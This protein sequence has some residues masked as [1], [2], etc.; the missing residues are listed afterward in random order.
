MTA[1]PPV[2]SEPPT[3]ETPATDVSEP[4][5]DTATTDEH[6]AYEP[7]DEPPVGTSIPPMITG[8]E[9]EPPQGP[10]VPPPIGEPAPPAGSRG[11]R[12][13]LRAAAIGALVGAVVAALVAGGLVAALDDDDDGGEVRTVEAGPA[14]LD[15]EA[16]DIRALL[17][18][19]EPSVVAIETG[20]LTESPLGDLDLGQAAGTGIILSEDGVVLTNNHVVEGATNIEVTVQDGKTYEA[21]LLGSS[22]RDDVALVKLRDANGLDAAELG[23]SEGLQVGDEVVAIGNALA[24]G[25]EP[26]VTRGIVS[27]KDR[28]IQAEVQGQPIRLEGL[29]QTDAAINSGNSGGPLVDAAGRVV[30]VNTAVA[31]GQ[32]QNIGFA[33]A[34]DTI[35]PLIE[36]LEE[37]EGEVVASAFL[38]VETVPVDALSDEVRESL[39]LETDTGALVRNVVPNSA[40]DDAGFRSGD[41]ITK[42]DDTEIESPEDLGE[43]IA[44]HEPGDTVTVEW[45]RRG[46]QETTEVE[47]GSREVVAD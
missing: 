30:G 45:E 21:D 29:I 25:D 41:V 6:P 34:I 2:P 20:V 10:P 16:L 13:S 47:L 32:A 40:A 44:E 22:P 1:E 36:R 18:V 23:N 24:L 5:P 46:R 12:G 3:G 8:G 28:E 35:K 26:T 33:I 27:A 31:G 38:G 11:G 15:D 19:I 14:A 4:Q 42:I 37:G 17:E 7:V 39:E 9:A 43:A